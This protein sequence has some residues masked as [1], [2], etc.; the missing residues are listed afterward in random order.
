MKS[1]LLNTL[2]PPTSP[3]TQ[4][5]LWNPLH[6]YTNND[7]ESDYFQHAVG[8]EENTIKDAGFGRIK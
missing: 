1:P 5:S 4:A 3:Q 7:L 8:G 2:A 6:E